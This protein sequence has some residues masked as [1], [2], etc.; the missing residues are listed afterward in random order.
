M[1][2]MRKEKIMKKE[3][4]RNA[5]GEKMYPVCSWER[6]QHV[7]YNAHDRAMNYCT[8]SNWC[9]DAV[10]KKNRVEMAIAAFESC[11][12][13]GIVYATYKDWSLI[14]DYINMYRARH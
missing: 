3:L 2:I 9:D 6:Y 8:E 14:H 1:E 4:P 10:A 5:K 11:I 12:I 13:D 7:L